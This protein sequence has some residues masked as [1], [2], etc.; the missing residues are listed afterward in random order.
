M[1]DQPKYQVSEFSVST[2]SPVVTARLHTPDCLADHPTLLLSFAGDRLTSLTVEP[3]CFA[4]KA[5]L[6]KGHRVMSIDL[7]NHGD[8]VDAFGEGITGFRNAFIAGADPF[9]L[10]VADGKAAIDTAIARGVAEPGRIVVCGTSRGGYMALRLLA[11]DVRV[12]AG[13]GFAP[14]T[15]WRDLSEFVLDR[16]HAKIAGLGLSRFSVAF[17]HKAIYLV[18]GSHDERVSTARCA[19]F[20]LDARH[21]KLAAGQDARDIDFFCTP[22]VGHTCSNEWYFR[23]A[24]FLLMSVNP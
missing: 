8:R 22:D 13:A 19:Q 21:S 20:Y 12:I 18:I 11:A 10:F 7:P 5:F 15:D 24:D 1:A 4:A 2:D 17:T 23:G 9:A 14:V 16:E 6:A 3:F